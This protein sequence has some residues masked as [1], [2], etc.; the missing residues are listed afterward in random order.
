MLQEQQR[1]EC[2]QE[3]HSTDKE[4]D[5]SK[6]LQGRR[7]VRNLPV[8]MNRNADRQRK[9][10]DTVRLQLDLAQYNLRR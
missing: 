1:Q 10:S 3:M 9:V 5:E 6:T 8:Q 7:S 2:S 4:A